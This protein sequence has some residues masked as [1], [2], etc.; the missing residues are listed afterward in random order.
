MLSCGITE[1]TVVNSDS[2]VIGKFAPKNV[3][4]L[5]Y[6]VQLFL[7]APL[8]PPLIGSDSEWVVSVTVVKTNILH[9]S[10]QGDSE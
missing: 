10:T 8:T 9:G 1:E 6:S 3:N 2:K 7:F 4:S 5:S